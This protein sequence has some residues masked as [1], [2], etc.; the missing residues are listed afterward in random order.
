MGLWIIQ[1]VD[2][3]GMEE[4]RGP[5]DQLRDTDLPILRINGL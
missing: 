2:R 1:L 3:V 5:T 4:S